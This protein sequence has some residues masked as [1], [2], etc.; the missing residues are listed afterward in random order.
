[1]DKVKQIKNTTLVQKLPVASL[2]SLKDNALHTLA[3]ADRIKLIDI[4]NVINRLTDTQLLEATDDQLFQLN[5]QRIKKIST[6]AVIQKLHQDKL[7]DLSDPA[8]T[9]LSI[10]QLKNANNPAL[11]ERLTDTQLLN[12]QSLDP[13]PNTRIQTIKNIQL[14][15]KLAPNQVDQLNNTQLANISENQVTQITLSQTLNRLTEDKIKRLNKTQLSQLDVKRYSDISNIQVKDIEISKLSMLSPDQLDAISDN[16]LAQTTDPETIIKIRNDKIAKLNWQQLR[17][18]DP[19]QIF[20]ATLLQKVTYVME[21]LACEVLATYVDLLNQIKPR[22]SHLSPFLLSEKT[23]ASY[24][25][26]YRNLLCA[27]LGDDTYYIQ[28]TAA[29]HVLFLTL[30]YSLFRGAKFFKSVSQES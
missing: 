23:R 18:I 13:L 29:V 6:E 21:I 28:V 5:N 12:T 1:R 26:R 24:H 7:A 8:L 16:Q 17:H 19:N 2:E 30:F 11:L 20:N 9:H 27:V 14:I 25:E 4:T 3:D 15:Q 10:N 22:S